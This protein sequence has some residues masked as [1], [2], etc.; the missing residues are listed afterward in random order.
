MWEFSVMLAMTP[1]LR[2]GEHGYTL[3]AATQKRQGLIRLYESV[4][5]MRYVTSCLQAV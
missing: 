5:A 3:A 2:S 4:D 1:L